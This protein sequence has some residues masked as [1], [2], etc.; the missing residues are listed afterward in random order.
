MIATHPSLACVGSIHRRVIA[1]MHDESAYQMTLVRM[2]A[3]QRRIT[4]A[5]TALLRLQALNVSERLDKTLI[6][7][8]GLPG[9][10]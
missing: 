1:T 9:L 5:R 6:E 4:E 8:H 2:F 3:T 10:R 7:L